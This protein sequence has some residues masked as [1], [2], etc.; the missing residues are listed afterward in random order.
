MKM[1]CLISTASESSAPCPG[2]KWLFHAYL[3][4][5]GG[6]HW[7]GHPWARVCPQA[8]FRA[9]PP[10]NPGGFARFAWSGEKLEACL[11]LP[12]YNILFNMVCA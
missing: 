2:H 11:V 10:H 6:G 9:L 5:G 8:G 12:S 4:P 7:H 3:A 1:S